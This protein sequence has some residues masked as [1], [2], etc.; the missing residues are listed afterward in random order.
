M[1]FGGELFNQ[2]SVKYFHQLIKKNLEKRRKEEIVRPDMIHLLMQAQENESNAEGN[3]RL[4][5]NH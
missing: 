1:F 4:T 5:S 2:E 3:L